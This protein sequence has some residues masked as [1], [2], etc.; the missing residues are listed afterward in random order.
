MYEVFDTFLAHGVSRHATNRKLF[1]LA[2]RQAIYNFDFNPDAM[3]RYFKGKVKNELL[4]S[5]I[6]DYVKD[7]AA[8]QIYEA[9][10][11]G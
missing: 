4:H 6:D 2:L 10:K 1:S 9:V 11:N 3:G 8:I 5:S 7:A